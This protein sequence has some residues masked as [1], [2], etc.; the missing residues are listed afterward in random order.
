MNLETSLFSDLSGKKRNIDQYTKHM[1]MQVF[2]PI[3]MK[4]KMMSNYYFQGL[5]IDIRLVNIQFK[6]KVN[7]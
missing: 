7:M 3:L 5:L 1:Q 6:L 2:R 4:N